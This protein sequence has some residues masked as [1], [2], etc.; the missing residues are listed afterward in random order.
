MTKQDDPS[1]TGPLTLKFTG[2]DD[3]TTSDEEAKEK[4][5]NQNH[6]LDSTLCT[7]NGDTHNLTVN[8]CYENNN[9]SHRR[10][11]LTSIPYKNYFEHRERCWTFIPN[12]DVI[13][14][15][16]AVSREHHFRLNP[17]FCRR[18]PSTNEQN[19][20]ERLNVRYTIT[21]RHGEFNWTITKKYKDLVIFFERMNVF[22][23][24]AA[25]PIP[26]TSHREIRRQMSHSHAVQG[27]TLKPDMLVDDSDINDR[28]KLVAEKLNSI[29]NHPVLSLH[30]ECIKFL[31]SSPLSFMRELGR[32]YK[33]GI[34]KKHSGGYRQGCCANIGARIKWLKRWFVT[35]DS[36]IAYLNP[37]TGH[38]RA[39]MLVDKFFHVR[40]GRVHT[41]SV[42]KIYICNLSRR[43][44]VSCP[45]ERKA[46][47]YFDDINR[48]LKT[49]GRDFHIET[50]FNSFAPI[51]V[52]T[53][54][55]WLVD[56]SDYM[57]AV[58]YAIKSATE[59]IYITDWFLSPEIYLKRPALSD[60]WRFDKMLEKKANEGV[61][62]FVLLY[63]EVELAIGIN[64]S[65]SKRKL[66][67]AHPENVKVLRYPDHTGQNAVLFWGHHEK[68]VIIDQSI[69]LFGGFDLCY[70]RWDNYQ[71]LLTDFG[72]A[73]PMKHH[74]SQS[75]PR[76]HSVPLIN[77]MTQSPVS[78]DALDLD[79]ATCN[80]FINANDHIEQ[81]TELTPSPSSR[82][83]TT[84][85]AFF[86]SK[87]AQFRSEYQLKDHLKE[88][89]SSD[90]I[91]H[92]IHDNFVSLAPNRSQSKMLNDQTSDTI[93]RIINPTRRYSSSDIDQQSVHL[94]DMQHRQLI[95]QQKKRRIYHF[96]HTLFSNIYK[97]THRLS[98]ADSHTYLNTMQN[99]ERHTRRRHQSVR[100]S[101]MADEHTTS[102]SVYSRALEKNTLNH[103]QEDN[104]E[105]QQ[106]RIYRTVLS[107]PDGGPRRTRASTSSRQRLSSCGNASDLQIENKHPQQIKMSKLNA[108]SNNRGKKI[109]FLLTRRRASYYPD[110]TLNVL[111]DDQKKKRDVI[112]PLKRSY[113]FDTPFHRETIEALNK[114]SGSRWERLKLGIQSKINRFTKSTEDVSTI[115]LSQIPRRNSTEAQPISSSNRHLG[116]NVGPTF[117]RVRLRDKLRRV[118]L[119]LK[120]TWKQRSDLNESDQSDIDHND[121]YRDSLHDDMSSFTGPS[122]KSTTNQ[123]GLQGS[124]K[125]W[126]GKDYANFLLRD[127]RNLDQ[128]FQDQID[129]NITPRMPWHDIG[130]FVY[131]ACARDL[132]RHFIERWNFVKRQ[133]IKDD[134]RYPFLLPKTYGIY[135]PC[136]KLLSNTFNCS[137]Q[138]LRSVG[139][140]S[141]GRNDTEESIHKALIDMITK[142][143][144]YIYIEN[145]FF[146]SLIDDSTVHNGIAEAL[147]K[148]ILRAHQEKETFRVYIVMPLIPGFEGQY[149]TSKATALQAITHWNYRSISQGQQ[150]LLVRLAKEVGDP[151]RYV[152]FFG[153][154]T[155]SEMNGRLVSEIVYAHS[156]SAIVD[157]NR[158]LI[159]SANINDRSLLGDRDSEISV[160]FEDTEFVRGMMN[161]Q[162]VQVGKFA[163][164]LRKRLFREHLGDF[165]G[166]QINYQD[167][168]SDSFYKDT[169][170][171]TA[172][173]NT[174]MFEKIFNCIPTD[175][176]FTFSQLREIQSSS[177]LCET[178]PEE[179][180]R[181]LQSIRGY[182]VLIPH[183]FL[184]KEYLGPRLPAKEILAPTWFWT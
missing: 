52:N 88:P 107:V 13:V 46:I 7:S 77:E 10:N 84:T 98:S 89:Y 182:L 176:A 87:I 142:A 144:Y 143:K 61:R 16:V 138:A 85:D 101:D 169:W 99:R 31:D 157:D 41:G 120:T 60:E 59:E 2:I 119:N 108:E 116:T 166:T 14:V 106:H 35:K 112:W 137:T 147:F 50:R 93:D 97:R 145:Q 136:P 80:R 133:K 180:R 55:Q 159:G 24:T 129:R 9:V 125:M 70:G 73:L 66:L 72:S 156:K 29:V 100:D 154:R 65:Y 79:S 110:N 134:E 42:N 17:F 181:L 22:Q 163:S 67:Q 5:T 162:N 78:I 149:G 32:K 175:S 115:A 43:L 126:F 123:L 128:P 69:A 135:T 68:L 90:S 4:N 91:S 179:A 127:F 111:S 20:L 161:G 82:P 86:P 1:F 81:K 18:Q 23:K 109:S 12:T 92:N 183:K 165:D 178:N 184:S 45:T 168:I 104:E 38:V 30:S 53:K 160:L 118:K 173:R 94:M 75:V 124:S 141:T 140:W 25:L 62:I 11:Q 139:R 63:K 27:L 174:T 19:W 152:C 132:A 155:W 170:L 74:P 150:S 131:G 57:E 95:E 54:C 40:T 21:L 15:N 113:S 171:S 34:V 6:P 56:G 83:I 105:E 114:D 28:E 146:V 130:A 44:Y 76:T 164:G 71:H 26:T 51:R 153:L 103:E 167:P 49:T 39:V 64:S 172:A 47:E 37:K 48:M 3:E 96:N 151:H 102:D 177:K 148:R 58:A 122:M 36:W 158:V 8:N 117:D 121:Y 33:E